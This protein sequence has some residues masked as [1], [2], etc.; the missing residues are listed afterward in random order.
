[1]KINGEKWTAESQHHDKTKIVDFSFDKNAFDQPI[2]KADG[3][4]ISG[5]GS[6]VTKLPEITK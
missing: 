5:E 2:T 3:N 4:K 6:T 1:M